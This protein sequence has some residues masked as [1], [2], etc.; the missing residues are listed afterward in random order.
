MTLPAGA[1]Q[2][3]DVTAAALVGALPDGVALYATAAI[4]MFFVTWYHGPMASAIDDA[5]PAALAA[6][7]QAVALFA[8]H[9]LGTAPSSWVLGLIC[10]SAGP[11]TAMGVAV[12][13]IAV[14]A[15]LVTRGEQG[16]T[17]VSPEEAAGP[18]F[19]RATEEFLAGK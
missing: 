17:W 8:T 3:P 12:G 2:P 9:L 19:L 6:T 13:A 16:V 7:A 15:L 11:R 10:R 18:E 1:K 5:A 4:A 14:A